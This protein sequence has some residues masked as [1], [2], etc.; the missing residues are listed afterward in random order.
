M[1]IPEDHTTMTTAAAAPTTGLTRFEAAQKAIPTT[2]HQQ[3]GTAHQRALEASIWP[4]RPRVAGRQSVAGAVRAEWLKLRTLVSTWITSAITIAIMVLF[5]AGLAVGYAGSP[6]R[7]D[8]AKDMISSGST[9]GMIVVAVLGALV[10]TGEYASG[11]I[12]SSVVAVPH[13]G[14]LFAAKALVVAAFSFILG[15]TSVLLSYAVSY[16]FMKGHAGSLTNTHY[17]GLFWGTGLSF[18]V[19]AL[20]AMGLGY[21]TRST[22]G[23]IT[24]VVSLLF[25]AP[26]PFGLMAGRWQWAVKVVGLLPDTV[27]TAV[28]D[29]FSLAHHWGRAG[30]E[31]FLQHWQAIAVFAAWA[32]IPLVIAGVIF[33]RRDA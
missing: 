4:T 1:R 26:I 22:A 10:V 29:P 20:M 31:T 3:P 19:I 2:A 17:L 8:V 9:L 21:L 23:A 15:V 25:V 27:S 33:T 13:R 16:P 11:Q 30:T 6:E 32:L 18:M 7:A 14:R 28:S 12:R 5:G 24:V